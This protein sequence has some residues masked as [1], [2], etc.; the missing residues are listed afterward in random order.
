MATKESFIGG[1][2]VEFD[3]NDVYPDGVAM[4]GFR[5]EKQ[6]LLGE[7]ATA[8]THAVR[9]AEFD[10]DKQARIVEVASIAN[11]AAELLS[12]SGDAEGELLIAVQASAFTIYA[13]S[14]ES[15]T[16][17]SPYIV[18]GDE[19]FWVAMGGRYANQ[20][21]GVAG[22]V[23]LA[24]DLAV[25]GNTSLSGALAVTG[26]SSLSTLATTGLSTLAL[27][28]LGRATQAISAATD[29]ITATKTWMHLTDGATG[30]YTLSSTPMIA[31]G[32]QGQILILTAAQ[33]DA[34]L[35]TLSDETQVA[36]SGLKLGAATR[37]LGGDGNNGDNK[38]L[39]LMYD[40]TNWV[41]IAYASIVGAA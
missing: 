2:K 21:L 12:R 37:T 25:T 5:T 38:V 14:E 39:V 11:P 8:A 34:A 4:Q 9:K 3:P 31:A 10:A 36:G 15:L 18:T 1:H 23:A 26:A 40:G 28:V 32:T 17:N 22:A 19:G 27:L 30:P 29:T 13:W 33:A 6:I 41:E 24:D 7:A 35:I 16:A 20:A